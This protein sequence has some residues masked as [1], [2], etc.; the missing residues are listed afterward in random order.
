MSVS[1]SHPCAGP[2]AA[3]GARLEVNDVDSKKI[4]VL[5][6]ES[7]DLVYVYLPEQGMGSCDFGHVFMYDPKDIPEST[8]VASDCSSVSPM[9]VAS[10]GTA[11]P[12]AVNASVRGNGSGVVPSTASLATALSPKNTS[13]RGAPSQ[14]RL[15]AFIILVLLAT[16]VW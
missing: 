6:V 12:S 5:W 9:H 7:R 11:L 16:L 2:I 10:C 13:Q 1:R 14:I 4:T 3:T 15:P 8:A